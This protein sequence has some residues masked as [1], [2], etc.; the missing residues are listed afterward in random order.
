MMFAI[1]LRPFFSSGLLVC[2]T[3]GLF[4]QDGSLDLSFGTD[5]S[6]SYDIGS[7]TFDLGEALTIQTDGRILV[8]GTTSQPTVDLAVLR[9]NTDGTLDPTFS[10]DG[11]ITMDLGQPRSIVVRPD[12]VI[13]VSGYGYIPDSSMVM[14]AFLPNGASDPSFGTNGVVH[15]AAPG[16]SFGEIEASVVQPDGSLVVTGSAFD[17]SSMNLLVARFLT[18]GSPDPTFD[19]DGFRLID[20]G[21][22][23][24]GRAVDLLPDGRIIIAGD[25]AI[26][27]QSMLVVR[28]N[29][30]GSYDTTFDLDGW[31]AVS[32]PVNV[33][34][35]ATDLALQ[36]DGKILLGG[37][38]YLD[39]IPDIDPV[40]VRLAPDGGLDPGFGNAGMYLPGGSPLGPVTGL[41]YLPDARIIWAA[42]Y[43]QGDTSAM[44]LTR[45]ESNGF[46]DSSFGNNGMVVQMDYAVV[47]DGVR[48]LEL[49][50]DGRI[51]LA[52][53]TGQG[54]AFPD[55][56][57]S[58]YLNG[59]SVGQHE[60]APDQ[61]GMLVYPGPVESTAWLRYELQNAED[62]SVRA[63]DRGGCVVR[64]F[65]MHA[66]RA[67]GQHTEP[68]DLTGLASGAYVI[69]VSG[70]DWEQS[71]TVIK[72]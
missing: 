56:A 42:N 44:T 50:Q 25:K 46:P 27:E 58:R 14:A 11:I 5:G 24:H 33:D 53:S 71:T 20:L 72:H 6:V 63:F 70:Y 43:D 17:G 13:L 47:D 67:P 39:A 65:F 1:P 59:L 41:A 19:G 45:L 69:K 49:Q 3:M 18:D 29:V 55:F 68:I 2:C 26:S 66:W 16:Q 30:D 23:E 8:A 34:L 9:L 32:G 12:G 54:G 31:T 60:R 15:I 52:G 10:M 61:F 4:A 37:T 38:A 7:G 28:L 51:V 35:D 48:A 40:L 62:L 64:S 22:N 36:D 21:G 57:V